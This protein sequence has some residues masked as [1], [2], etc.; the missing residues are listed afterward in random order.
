M[1]K[2]FCVFAVLAVVL[3]I[4]SCSEMNDSISAI[5]DYVSSDSDDEGKTDTYTD[6]EEDEERI[7][8]KTSDLHMVK[9]P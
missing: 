8:I 5:R 1:K 2:A 4:S 9:S 6:D 3:L 7:T